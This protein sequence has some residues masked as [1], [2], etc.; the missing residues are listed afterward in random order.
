MGLQDVL[1][2]IPLS[3]RYYVAFFDGHTPSYIKANQVNTLTQEQIFEIN[4]VIINNCY[5]KCV[6]NCKFALERALS[7][8]EY[9]SPCATY[10][11]GSGVQFGATLKKEI[12]YHASDRD[13]WELFIG[14][15]WTQFKGLSRNDICLCGSTKKFKKC[16]IAKVKVCFRMYA[17]IEHKRTYYQVHDDAICEKAIAEFYGSE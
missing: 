11:G 14:N 5:K 16:C 15:S 7:T 8:F 3:A 2:L 1:I 10:S 17:D 12:F 9:Q 13:A 6:G 4:E